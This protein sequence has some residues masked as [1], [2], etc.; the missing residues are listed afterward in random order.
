MMGL[1]KMT[2]MLLLVASIQL[3]L[4]KNHTITTSTD[5]NITVQN[6][7]KKWK[8]DKYKVY[9]FSEAPAENEKKDYIYLKSDLTFDSIS[10]GEFEAGNWRLDAKN[11][12]IHLSKKNEAG[13]VVFIIDE[14]KLESLVLIIDD[15]SDSDAQYL[16][17]HFKI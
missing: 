5:F 11:K 14:L 13:D 6:L 2:T 8:L 12:R 3:H 15:P 7:S 1:F 4:I 9:F 10:E 17:I 16:K